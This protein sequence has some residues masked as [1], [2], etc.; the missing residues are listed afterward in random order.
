VSD[1]GV[2]VASTM[3]E[4]LRTCSVIIDGVTPVRRLARATL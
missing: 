3:M 1:G 4:P 2:I